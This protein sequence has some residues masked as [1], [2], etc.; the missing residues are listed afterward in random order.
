M[1]LS[2]CLQFPGVNTW[3]VLPWYEP[4]PSQVKWA[5]HLSHEISVGVQRLTIW[6][7]PGLSGRV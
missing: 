7:E 5:Q 2:P 4:T 3:S 6:K 1:M